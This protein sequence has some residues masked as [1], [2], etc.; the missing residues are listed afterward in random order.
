MI[1][2]IITLFLIL[3]ISLN[4]VAQ[5]RLARAKDDLKK[6]S[7][8]SSI[9]SSNSDDDDDIDYSF[10]IELAEP[11]VRVVG[12]ISYGIL[13]ESEW[14]LESNMHFA[15]FTPYPYAFGNYGD[16]IYDEPRAIDGITPARVT[17]SNNFVR[18]D[19]KLWGNHLNGQLR[20]EKRFSI[21]AGYLQ[22]FEQGPF[23]TESFSLFNFTANYYR[24]R[25]PNFMLWYGPGITYVGNEVDQ[26][27]F[28][29]NGGAEWFL[30]KP[31]SLYANYKH[32]FLGS[33]SV[34]ILESRLKY[35]LKRYHLSGGFERYRLGSVFISNVAFGVGATF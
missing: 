2:S 30:G 19:S 13:V 15:R 20:F 5:T 8:S 6:S 31:I 33:D 7:S 27:G 12:F 24:I 17:I 26:F 10:L 28:T 14:E 4:T 23:G 3:F 29:L 1:R 18:A 22:L 35:H 25:T 34:G 32:A 16:Y 21:D 11:L 9:S